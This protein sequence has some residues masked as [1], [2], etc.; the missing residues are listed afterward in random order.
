MKFLVLFLLLFLY[1]CKY[2]DVEDY[3]LVL[4]VSIDYENE[5]LVMGFEILERE[6]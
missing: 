3:S 1:G 6:N 2:H 4:G 5:G